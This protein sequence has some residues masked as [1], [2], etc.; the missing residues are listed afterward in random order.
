M[1]IILIICC[2]ITAISNVMNTVKP[3][4]AGGMSIFYAAYVVIETFIYGRI[5]PGYATIV[6]AIFFLGG[7]QLLSI[8]ILGEY[9]ASLFDEVKKRP[10]YIISESHKGE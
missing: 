9:L 7:V 8:G 6:T 2:R 4:L 10:I 5:V 1:I 3:R